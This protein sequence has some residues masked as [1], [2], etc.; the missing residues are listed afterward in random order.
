MAWHSP[1]LQALQASETPAN[2]QLMHIALTQHDNIVFPQREQ[3]LADAS[4]T[5]FKGLGHLELCLDARVIAWLV[6]KLH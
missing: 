6:Q 4:V 3:V 1:W 5:E 2:R